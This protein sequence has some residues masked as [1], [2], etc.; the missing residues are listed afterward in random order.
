MNK[1]NFKIIKPSKGIIS[2]VIPGDNIQSSIPKAVN[3][4][5]PPKPKK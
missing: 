1:D 4:P 2:E 3:V 5:P